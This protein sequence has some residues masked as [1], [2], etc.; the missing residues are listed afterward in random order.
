MNTAAG[1]VKF[2][3]IV[4]TYDLSV[5]LQ[6]L[7]VYIYIVKSNASMHIDLNKLH[8]VLA[9]TSYMLDGDYIHD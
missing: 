6:T 8:C 5:S 3:I 2:A 9:Y 1:Q 4:Y 7:H